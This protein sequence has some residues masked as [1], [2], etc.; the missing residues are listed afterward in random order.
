MLWSA[1]PND[2]RKTNENLVKV[3]V[4]TFLKGRALSCVE[5]N[6]LLNAE[7]FEFIG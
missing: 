2:A 5:E 4:K 1:A 3:K 7:L 6:P